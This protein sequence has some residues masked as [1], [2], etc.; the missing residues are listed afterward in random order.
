MCVL[1]FSIYLGDENKENLEKQRLDKNEEV[2]ENLTSKERLKNEAPIL[3]DDLDT[4]KCKF[5]SSDSI[6]KYTKEKIDRHVF[7]FHK[8]KKFFDMNGKKIPYSETGYAQRKTFKKKPKPNP[9]GQ[10]SAV[11]LDNNTYQYK[12][13]YESSI[14][15]SEELHNCEKIKEIAPNSRRKQNFESVKGQLISERNFGV[16]KSSK[17]TN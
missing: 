13:I 4:Y 7:M 12:T 9:R 5:C 10:N 1:F 3:H 2:L 8:D 14:A 6:L 16:F 11:Y 17:K 15:K